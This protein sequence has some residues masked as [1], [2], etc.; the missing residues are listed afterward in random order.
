VVVAGLWYDGGVSAAVKNWL[1]LAAEDYDTSLYLFRGARYPYAVYLLC[2]AVEKTLKAAQVKITQQ[3]PQKIH[4]LVHLG[5]TSGLTLT[6]DH[7]KTLRVLWT[8]Y[9]R[10][11]YRD[12]AQ[13]SYNTKKKVAPI[14]KQGKEMYRWIIAE[15]ENR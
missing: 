3:K 5:R 12:L 2:Q 13:A 7:Q 8:H 14:I 9:K 4:D 11:R 15:L 6:T 10:V 1:D